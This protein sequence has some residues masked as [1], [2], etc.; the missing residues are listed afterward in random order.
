MLVEK[1]RNNMSERDL[2]RMEPKVRELKW[3]LN[4]GEGRLSKKREHKGPWEIAGW[5]E[6][7]MDEIEF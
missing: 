2:H 1:G 4:R 7:R 5:G 6:V 3:V